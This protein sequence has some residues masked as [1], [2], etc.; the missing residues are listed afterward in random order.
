[1][2]WNRPTEKTPVSRLRKDRKKKGLLTMQTGLR[3]ASTTYPEPCF[4]R[5]MCFHHCG[6]VMAVIEPVGTHISSV[7]SSSVISIRST[8]HLFGVP[9]GSQHS[10][11]TKILSPLVKGSGYTA[12]G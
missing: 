2:P 9:S 1:M 6:T 12:T 7:S 3:M 10:A 11:R 4:V 8:P 5:A